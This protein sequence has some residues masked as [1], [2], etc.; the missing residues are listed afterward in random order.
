MADK[1]GMTII[2]AVG[3]GQ[4]PPPT[5]SNDKPSK[6]PKREGKG[7][8]NLPIDALTSQTAEGG[9]VSPE[10]GDTV[11]LN[12]VAGEVTAVEN[13]VATIDLKSV[14]GVPVEYA[15]HEDAAEEMPM[16]DA[17]GDALLEAAMAADEEGGY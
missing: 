5:G 12:D 1:K 3:G 15:A 6:K 13:G 4:K 7:M 2:I 8:I 14:G 11:S 17:E 16:D 9:D 10:V